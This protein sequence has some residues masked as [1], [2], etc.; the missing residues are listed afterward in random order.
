MIEQPGGRWS[1]GLQ[2]WQILTRPSR[3]A[4]WAPVGIILAVDFLERL[5]TAL[6]AIQKKDAL[7]K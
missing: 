3:V 2:L 4:S 1:L 6:G 5:C 7:C